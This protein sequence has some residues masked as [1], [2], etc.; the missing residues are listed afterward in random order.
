MGSEAGELD[1]RQDCGETQAENT[2]RTEKLL[3]TEWE[4][5]SLQRPIE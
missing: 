2:H 1:N 3:R 4:S 5:A